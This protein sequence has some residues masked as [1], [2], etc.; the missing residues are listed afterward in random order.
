MGSSQKIIDYLNQHATEL[1]LGSTGS[2]STTIEITIDIREEYKLRRTL[3]QMVYVRL[4]EDGQ[5]IIVIGQIVSIETRNRWHE[6]PAFKGVIK[7][8]GTLPHLSEVADSRVA[9]ISVQA[10]YNLGSLDPEGYI[11]GNSPSTGAG[12]ELMN[13]TMMDLLM[14]VYS[15]N[16]TYLGHFYNTDV[17]APFW[18]KHF[19]K[20]DA[21]NGEAG[22]GDAYHI[23]VFGKT[24]SGKSNTAASMLLGYAKNSHNMNILILDPQAQFYK[25][26]ELLP[27]EGRSFSEEVQ[28]RGMKF[29]R[30]HILHDI[31]LPGDMFELFG[32]LLVGTQFIQ[33][34]FG[35]FYQEEKVEEAKSEIVSYLASR[36]KD[37]SFSLETINPEQLLR[38][39]VKNFAEKTKSD[40]KNGDP[41]WSKFV[42]NVYG[43]RVT[44]DRLQERVDV[45]YE[46][47]D[48]QGE[49]YARWSRAINYFQ[50]FNDGRKKLS[51]E[52]LVRAMVR[53]KGYMVVLNLLDEEPTNLAENIQAVFINEI[54]RRIVEEGAKLY[55][56]ER[57]NC[58]IVL[59]EAH[60]FISLE[61]TDPHIHELTR[62]IIAS[63][64][65]TRKYGIGYMFITQTIE[66]LDSEILK[67]MRIFAFG[68]GLTTAQESRKVADII[69]NPAAMH[70]YQSFIDPSSNRKY[71]FMFYGPISPL[72]FTGSPL[73]V[74]MYTSGSDT[75]E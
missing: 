10:A 55:G 46:N 35:K 49:V 21:E 61:N 40:S 24:G 50:R 11:L 14:D 54:E 2:P 56:K 39:M 26:H 7:R 16:V 67:Q 65:T 5:N 43:T 70:L 47:I 8:Y 48:L 13:N 33:L 71:P 1:S 34:A 64:R 23:G 19:G 18:F 66:S 69:N 29:K 74:N 30:L 58:L 27:G 75:K 41:E 63:V 15:H 73:F 52:S 72:S 25:D 57:A 51:V 59:D 37:P 12:V 38:Q 3:G 6:D 9:T 60:R 22:A 45:L 42:Y 17:H 4:T 36:A 53:D 62:E 28:K 32:D 44:R 31:H 68:Y 20:D